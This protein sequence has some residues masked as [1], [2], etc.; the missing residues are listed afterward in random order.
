MSF[1]D[2]LIIARSSLTFDPDFIDPKVPTGLW[3]CESAEDVQA[4]SINAVKLAEG[5]EWKDLLRCEKFLRSFPYVFVA[6][7]NEERRQAIVDRLRQVL[8]SLELYIPAPGV[9]RGC[10]SVGEFREQFGLSRLQELLIDARELPV[11]GLLNLSDIRPWSSGDVPRY[12]S[13]VPELDRFTGGFYGGQLSLWTGERGLGK[14]TLLS[15]FLLEAVDQGAVVCA[16]SGELS[17]EQFKEWAVIQA[18]GPGHVGV[19]EDKETGRI[20]SAVANSVRKRIDEWWDKRFFLYDVGTASSHSEDTILSV[21]E[22]AQRCYGA[23]VFL[24]DNI[25]TIGLRGG[26][27]GEYFRAQSH[28]AGRLVQFA[29]QHQA[30]VHL[31]AHPRKGDSSRKHLSS[32]DVAGTGDLPNRADNVFA[33]EKGAIELKGKQVEVRQIHCLKNRMFGGSGAKRV[34][35][36]FDVKSRRFYRPGEA[37][38]KQYGWE[39]QGEQVAIH[40]IEETADMPF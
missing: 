6:V 20:L 18:A 35:M 34:A 29:K 26:R 33:L 14:S 19:Y 16:Y 23:S 8:P 15:Q 40:E 4:V 7:A 10:R 17:R 36:A 32:D 38:D 11:Y 39:R 24:V 25:M 30:H 27:D 31:V 12:R 37:A 21:F 2:Q 9:F 22:N 3:F 13:G 28:F 1:G 5:A